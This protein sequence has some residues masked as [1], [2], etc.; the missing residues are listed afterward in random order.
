VRD[1]ELRMMTNDD[2][3]NIGPLERL[4]ELDCFRAMSR[5]NLLTRECNGAMFR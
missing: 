2:A 5:D 3:E 4:V 1:V